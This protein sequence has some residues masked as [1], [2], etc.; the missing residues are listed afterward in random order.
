MSAG[1]RALGRT[2]EDGTLL[3]ELDEPPESL[4]FEE[5]ALRAVGGDL[6]PHALPAVARRCVYEV[7][8]QPR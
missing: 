1:E 3:L 7:R 8:L 6:D 5:G 4:T 2:G